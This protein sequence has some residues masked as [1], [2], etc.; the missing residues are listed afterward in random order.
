M[1]E[2]MWMYL[3]AVLGMG[4]IVLINFFGH[5]VVS[6]EQNYYLLKEVTE[7]AMYDAV[8]LTAYR[9]GVGY[10]GITKGED[11]EEDSMHCIAGEP[12][13][14]RIIR[15]KFV[16]SFIRRFAENAELNR[17]YRVVI[18]DIDECPPKVSLSL[19]STTNFDFATFLKIDFSNGETNIPSDIVNSITGILETPTPDNYVDFK[20]S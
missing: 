6:N 18:H 11:G 10:D 19:I 17:N 5:I 7:A 4:G 15:E 16:E 20:K 9:I 14:I 13:T 8:D 2:S 12:G 3:F 1:K